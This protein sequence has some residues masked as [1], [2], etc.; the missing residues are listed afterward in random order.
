MKDT[1]RQSVWLK[2]IEPELN[3]RPLLS[4]D[5]FIQMAKNVLEVKSELAKR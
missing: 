5:C 4:R 2:A 3:L 1:T